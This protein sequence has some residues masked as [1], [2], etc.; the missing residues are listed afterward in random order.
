MLI[1]NAPSPAKPTTGILGQ[2]IL[3]PRTDGNPYPHGPNNP[4]AR[5]FL[6]SSKVGYALPM[7]QLFPI[8]DE[9]MASRGSAD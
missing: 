9:I 7:A 4:G 2:P 3:A 5:Y 8:S 6:P 1:P